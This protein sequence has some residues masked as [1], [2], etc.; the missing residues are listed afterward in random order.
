MTPKQ[1]PVAAP[2]LNVP[3]AYPID[4][5]ILARLPRASASPAQY[6]ADAPAVRSSEATADA[7]LDIARVGVR[8]QNLEQALHAYARLIEKGQLLDTVI[9]DLA[10]L[11]R[12]FP[13]NPLVWKS[14]GDA[15]TRAG[16]TEY[17]EKAYSQF[18]LLTQ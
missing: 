6:S 16:K 14:L 7:I 11:A 4:P 10:G 15:L 2:A 9:Q 17:A 8:Q 12:Q 1:A 18:R 3:P 13:A 5:A